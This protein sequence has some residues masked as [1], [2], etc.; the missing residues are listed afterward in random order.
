MTRDGDGTAHQLYEAVDDG[1]AEA[2][3]HI[4][5]GIAGGFLLE[6]LEEPIHELF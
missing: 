6:G 1:K 5:P 2:A 3:P 4:V